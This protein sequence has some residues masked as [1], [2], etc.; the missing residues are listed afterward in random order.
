MVCISASSSTR[1]RI[2]KGFRE[3]VRGLSQDTPITI[4]S[5]LYRWGYLCHGNGS[6]QRLERK[7]RRYG[8][9]C[10]SLLPLCEKI[11]PLQK[12]FRPLAKMSSSLSSP[13]SSIGNP[14]TTLK[15]LLFLSLRVYSGVFPIFIDS[16]IRKNGYH[17]GILAGTCGTFARVYNR[18]FSWT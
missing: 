3:A 17:D 2:S 13:P 15:L 5:M 12:I 1:L 11:L 18:S 10:L 7:R 4:R 6:W 9:P 14:I 8:T 16:H